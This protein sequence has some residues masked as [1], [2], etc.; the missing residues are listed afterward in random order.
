MPAIKRYICVLLIATLIIAFSCSGCKGKKEKGGQKPGQTE[1]DSKELLEDLEETLEKLFVTLDG[2]SVDDTG[3]GSNDQGRSGTSSESG[4]AGKSQGE[5]K[6]NAQKKDQGESQDQGKEQDQSKSQEQGKEQGEEKGKSQGQD[7]EQKQ[8]ESQNVDQGQG[9]GQA[10][11]QGESGEA[12]W[13]EVDSSVNELHYQ[14]NNYMPLAA[15]H[16][17][18]RRLLDD[19]STSLDSLTNTLITKNKI[20]ILLD[21]SSLYSNIP[22]LYALHG[23]G[24]TAEIKRIRH[25][26]RNAV[27]NAQAANWKQVNTDLENLIGTWAIYKNTIPAELQETAARLDFSINEFQRVAEEQNQPLC[28]IK[29]KITISNIKDTEKA[30]E[31]GTGSSTSEGEKK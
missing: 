24:L 7:Q 15:K 29:G 6:N 2:P 13:S 31:K 16:G 26:T 27:L 8:G 14:W 20:E 4:N 22:E 12:L 5:D 28:T 11:K 23:N 17:A 1:D 30:V 9:Q 10:E 19:F 25:Y 18:G 21:A 3:K